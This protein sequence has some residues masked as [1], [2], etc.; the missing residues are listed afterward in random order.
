MQWI[1]IVATMLCST[2]LFSL[3]NSI[4][5]EIQPAIINS[6][7]GVD[8]LGWLGAAFVLG[9]VSTVIVW[10]KIMGV[11]SVK[12]TYITAVVIFEVGSAI[13]GAAPDMDAMIV[14][15]AIAGVGGSGMYVGCLALLSMTTTLR[16]RP[17][18]MAT[19]GFTW[20]SGT[21][22]GPIVGGAFAE[23]PHTTWRWSFY[24]N[25]CIGAL[26]APAC[27]FLLPAADPQKGVPFLHR[28]RH[29]DYLGTI[30]NIGF[31][32]PL[33]MAI[34]FG[35]TVYTWSSGQEIA[36]WVVT[37]VVFIA[38]CHQQK[39]S[40]L[41]TKTNR[42]FPG[43]FLR[44]Y[45]MWLLFI[46]MA[47]ASGAVFV[48]TYFIPL[49]FQFVRNDAPLTAGVRL[50]PFIVVMVFFGLL[51][52]GL[53][54]KSGYYMPWYLIGGCLTLTGGALM[55]TVNQDTSVAR[56][57][58]YE[59]ITGAGAGLYIQV[60]YAVA[61]AKVPPSRVADAA[62]FISFA[63]YL[64]ITLS[65][66]ISGT[67]FQNVAFNRLVPLFPT[68]QSS[69]VRDIITGTSGGFLKTLDADL[70]RRVLDVIIHAMSLTYILV[71]TAGAV[72]V[73]A[74]SL[75]KRKRLYMQ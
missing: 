67:V 70:A 32:V 36:L 59:A 49:Y 18:Y 39:F 14:G 60:S 69:F 61:Q 42:L 51:S 31:L 43:D 12:W 72:T 48:P 52:G 34:N 45:E 73:I 20:G 54:S 75:M 13:C 55:H 71:L 46:S 65:L 2:F 40:F 21:V 30:L 19:T 11:F 3:D 63:Q 28:V 41:T 15:R 50:L 66:A 74:A 26:F 10:G 56:V 16:E 33:I 25:L 29:L 44:Q 47:C 22:L 38:Y 1:I 64:G 35:G 5:A 37:A 53:I 9:A 62:G 17:I 24:I 8:R 57:Y 23:N 6:L 4:V 27:L 58:G 7:G 68:E